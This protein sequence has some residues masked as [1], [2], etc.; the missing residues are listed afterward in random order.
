MIIMI[1][2]DDNQRVSPLQN[3]YPITPNCDYSAT[4]AEG[5]LGAYNIGEGRF[6]DPYSCGKQFDT[7]NYSV[8]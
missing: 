5:I 6:E 8:S 3:H 1:C 2:A 4:Y 7:D